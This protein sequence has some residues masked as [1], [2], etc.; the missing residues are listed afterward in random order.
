MTSSQNVVIELQNMGIDIDIN[1]TKLKAGHG[2]GVCLVLLKLTQAGLARR[3]QYQT[4]TIRDEGAGGEDDA[5]DTYGLDDDD[6]CRFS[7]YHMQ[8]F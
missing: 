1:P 8:C 6:I 5:D 7:R 3:F 2:E 4:P